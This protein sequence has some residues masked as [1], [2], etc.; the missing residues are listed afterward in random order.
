MVDGV[1]RESTTKA[2]LRAAM[3]AR[4]RALS[5]A[6]RREDD[7]ALGRH[8]VALAPAPGRTV[9]AYGPVGSEPGSLEALD[10]L[11]AAGVRVLLPVA[12]SESGVPQP[13]RWGEYRIGTLVEAP[14]GLREPPQPWLSA[15]AIAAASTLLIPALA[16]DYA[17]V[18]LGRG[19]GFYDRSLGLADPAARLVAVVRDDEL[20]EYVPGEQHDVPMTHALTPGRG[21]VALGR[22]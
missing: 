10:V 6:R 9:C 11:V 15:S 20:V 5:P 8:L 3:V 19:A 7:V 22:S 1:D 17:G 16:V 4:R 18:R 13:L 14:Y 21:L 2:T 12:R